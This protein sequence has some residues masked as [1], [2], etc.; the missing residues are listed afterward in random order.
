MKWLSRLFAV[1]RPHTPLNLLAPSL[2]GEV[3]VHVMHDGSR[4]VFM[5]KGEVSKEQLLMIV[6]S[7]VDAGIDLANQHGIQINFQPGGPK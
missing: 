5:A 3:H 4:Q 7:V 2:L 6:K 1:H